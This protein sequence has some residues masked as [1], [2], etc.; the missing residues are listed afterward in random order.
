MS[1]VDE[2]GEVLATF[3]HT[4]HLGIT[5]HH[6]STDNEGHVIVADFTNDCVLLLN[7]EL[8]LL[9]VLVDKNSQDELWDPLRLHYNERTSELYVAHTDWLS[10]KQL[11]AKS[12]SF[13]IA[14]FSL[15]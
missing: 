5:S 4:S 9:Q 11:N 13:I 12:L 3:S 8:K 2:K 15:Q 1:E 10:F 7:G 14:K 6:L